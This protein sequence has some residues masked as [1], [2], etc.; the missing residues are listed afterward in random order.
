MCTFCRR[1]ACNY[2][3]DH[4]TRTCVFHVVGFGGG[5]KFLDEYTSPEP[6]GHRATQQFEGNFTSIA[7]PP[8]LSLSQ[9][10]AS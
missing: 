3:G 4:G 8:K 10:A 1:V 5:P 6:H 2:F 9:P 7:R